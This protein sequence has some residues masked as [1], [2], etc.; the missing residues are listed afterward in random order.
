MSYE[1]YTEYLCDNGHYWTVRTSD[2][3]FE[4]RESQRL[5]CAHCGYPFAF[6][7]RVDRTNGT[8][9]SNPLSLEAPKIEYGWEDIQKQDHWKNIYFEKRP[10]FL[11]DVLSRRW[12]VAIHDLPTPPDL[13][14]RQHQSTFQH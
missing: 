8:D 4:G 9:E 2:T 7:S 13:R 10:L 3:N 11:P 14:F 6:Q 12:Q 5:F 1:G